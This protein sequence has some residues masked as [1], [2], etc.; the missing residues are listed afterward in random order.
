MLGLLLMVLA[1]MLPLLGGVWLVNACLPL[2]PAHKPQ[3]QEAGLTEDQLFQQQLLNLQ[4][5][6]VQAMHAMEQEARMTRAERN[7]VMA[8]L[9]DYHN[10]PRN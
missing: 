1:L 3:E 5:E 8:A 10:Q 2:P 7:A 6:Y 4:R 9:H